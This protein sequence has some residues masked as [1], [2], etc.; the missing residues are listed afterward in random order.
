MVATPRIESL[1]VGAS[2]VV[3]RFGDGLAVEATTEWI[4]DACRCHSCRDQHSGQHL[5]DV[6]E[7]SGWEVVR[8]VVVDDSLTVDLVRLSDAH[9][10]RVSDDA[11]RRLGS[12]P[13]P[14]RCTWTG[15]HRDELVGSSQS[16]PAAER[17]DELAKDLVRY[18]IALGSRLEPV[19]RAV[20]KLAHALGFVRETVDGEIFDLRASD[21]T[22]EMAHTASA[23]ALQTA[24]P[25]R[26]A[27]PAVQVLH[28]LLPAAVS[29]VARFVDGFAAVECLRF[30]EPD[31][32]AC[33]ATTVVEF[34][35][36]SPDVDL[37]A[38]RCIIETDP[39]GVVRALHLHHQSMEPPVLSGASARRFYDAYRRLSEVIQDPANV[40]ELPVG[41]GDVVV[42]DGRRVLHSRTGNPRTEPRHLQGCYIDVDA[43]ESLARIAE[44]TRT[45]P[46]FIEQRLF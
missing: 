31:A 46:R 38:R 3:V 1:S 40:M 10:V 29:G 41:L 24:N 22:W 23:R 43:V 21:T 16:L 27:M 20:L 26:E 19:D 33:L 25:Y 18:G 42:F 2:G 6:F 4:R 8:A 5:C 44:R 17:V 34:R 15:L 12:L 11:V 37:R 13:R 28:C 30:T 35:S 7:L 39:A 9:R 45:Q 14:I 36:S 32:F